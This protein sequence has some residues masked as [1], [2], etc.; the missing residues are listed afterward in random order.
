MDRIDQPMPE[1]TENFSPSLAYNTSD[2]NPLAQG[3]LGGNFDIFDLIGANMPLPT[4]PYRTDAE[5]LGYNMPT[6]MQ[7]NLSGTI[8]KLSRLYGNAPLIDAQVGP[9]SS[10]TLE[11]NLLGGKPEGG[12]YF[13]KKF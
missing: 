2:P 8:D 6:K 9:D 1:P 7:R 11:G 10:I 5:I 12:I 13:T 4:D 3:R